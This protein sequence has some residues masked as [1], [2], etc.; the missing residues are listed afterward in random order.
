MF[1]Y[2]H[3]LYYFLDFKSKNFPDFGIRIPFHGAE[4]L[5]FHNSSDRTGELIS[6]ETDILFWITTSELAWRI[7]TVDRLTNKRWQR[8]NDN[9]I[10]IKETE[11]H[12]NIP[13][14]KTR[15]LSPCWIFILTQEVFRFSLKIM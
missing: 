15:L 1:S 8:L 4:R 3:V 5:R 11:I 2:P 13:E 9:I 12:I 10:A 14:K 7:L 6:A